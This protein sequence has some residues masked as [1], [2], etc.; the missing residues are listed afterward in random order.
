MGRMGP[1]ERI[2]VETFTPF[3][4]EY[5]AE[6]ELVT[7]VPNFS[8]PAENQRKLSCFAVRCCPGPNQVLASACSV[9]GRRL[10][11]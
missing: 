7:I 3:E 9:G 2:A 10:L 1:A 8:L 4:M 5:F 6:D 11:F